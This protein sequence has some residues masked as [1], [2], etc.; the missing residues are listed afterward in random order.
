MFGILVW[1]MEDTPVPSII[2]PYPDDNSAFDDADLLK[3]TD[4][5]KVQV[6]QITSPEDST[7]LKSLRKEA[8]NE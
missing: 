8:N 4:C 6:T 1:L 7:T 2:G 5:Y 3:K